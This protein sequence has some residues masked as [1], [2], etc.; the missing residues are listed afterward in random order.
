MSQTHTPTPVSTP[1]APEAIG[2][3]SQGVIAGNLLFVSGQL[4]IDPATGSFAE[5]GIQGRTEQCLQNVKAIAESVGSSLERAVKMTIFLTDMNDFSMVN[6]TYAKFFPTN[7]PARS[8]IQVAG[9]PKNADVEI[10][11]VLNT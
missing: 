11:A 9:L 8:A 3:Y 2:P 7:P 10:E 4:P 1:S 6:E 5:G